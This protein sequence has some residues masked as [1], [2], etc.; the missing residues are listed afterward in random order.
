MASVVVT[1]LALE[2]AFRL[3]GVSVGTVQI[4]R[5]TVRRTDDPLLRFE[6]RPG[7]F[8]QAEVAY[9]IN[10]LG[11]R[12]PETTVEKPPGVER[13]AVLGD[14]IAFGY[15]VAEEDAFPRQLEALVSSSGRRV[16][17]LDF[18]VPG[19]NLDQQIAALRTKALAFSPDLVVVAF[20]LNDLEGVFSYELGLVQDRSVRSGTLSGRARET[21]LRRSVLVSW[22]EYRLSE[23][24]ARRRFVRARNPVDGPM[25]A[26]TVS[27]QEQALD[28]KLALLHALLASRGIPGLVVVFPVMGGRFDR[29]PHGALHRAVVSSAERHGLGAVDLLDC[30]SAYDFRDL[31]VDVVHPGPLGHRV[32]AHAIRDALCARGWLC[33]GGAPPRPSCRDYRPADFPRVRGY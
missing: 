4:N 23:L 24:E 13:V 18:G 17:V 9:R 28:G 2:A 22:V 14:S 8:A 33:D 3:V 21:L 11:L 10:A 31:R 6:L 12:G 1:A 5:E 20:C 19:Y 15:W 16:E 26:E 30:Y 32:A 7:G 25:D 29:Y 27:Q